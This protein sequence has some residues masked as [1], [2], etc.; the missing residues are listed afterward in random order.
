MITVETTRAQLAIGR[1]SLAYDP[2]ARVFLA[3]VG[4]APVVGQFLSETGATIGARFTIA[5]ENFYTAWAGVTA[6]GSSTDPVFLI[7]YLR[8]EDHSKYARFVRYRGGNPSVSE[9]IALGNVGDEWGHS[10]KGQSIWTGTAFVVG[11]R[12]P[13]PNFPTVQLQRITIDGSVSAP[14]DIG[15][16]ADYYGS[17]AL[18]LGAGGVGLAI[19]FQAG[20]PN[21]TGGTYGR[22]FNADTL[23]PIGSMLR[24]SA[25]ANENQSVTYE[26]HAGVFLA[27]WLQGEPSGAVIRLKTVGRDGAIG[28]AVDVVGPHGTDAGSNTIAYNRATETTLLATKTG[29]AELFLV[30]LGDDGRPIG[31]WAF[32]TDW[33]G[34]SL[35]YSTNVVA[36]PRNGSWLATATQPSALSLAVVQGQAIA[37]DAAGVDLDLFPIAVGAMV[38]AGIYLLRENVL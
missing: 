24:L 11:T 17:P 38:L 8:A 29:P 4:V 18:A 14:V 30:E 1:N 20:L 9:P 5:G 32:V 15:D 16:H 2:T 27:S 36:N 13:A 12:V 10:E 37:L 26:T 21:Y 31:P 7:T 25:G 3:L 34:R 22:L 28:A 23:Q 35:D 19:G 6:G 33:D